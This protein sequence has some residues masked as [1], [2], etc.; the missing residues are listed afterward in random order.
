MPHALDPS[1][2]MHDGEVTAYKVYHMFEWYV[3]VL[4]VGQYH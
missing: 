3:K 4:I 2:E 1:D